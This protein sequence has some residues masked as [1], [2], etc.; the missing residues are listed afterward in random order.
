MPQATERA[1]ATLGLLRELTVA[2]TVVKRGKGDRPILRFALV[3]LAF[4]S[5]RKAI[6]LLSLNRGGTEGA[7]ILGKA[8]VRRSPT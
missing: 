3:C 2:C 4:V 6:A 5:Y 7:V 1:K 8:I